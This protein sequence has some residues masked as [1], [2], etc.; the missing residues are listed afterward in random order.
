[1]KIERV[2]QTGGLMFAIKDSEGTE[3]FY[4][5]HSFN[6]LDDCFEPV[7]IKQELK[8]EHHPVFKHWLTTLPPSMGGSRWAE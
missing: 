7:S 4:I 1:M 5:D 2:K 6:I 3:L 8:I